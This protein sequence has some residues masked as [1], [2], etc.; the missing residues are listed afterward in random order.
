[1]DNVEHKQAVPLRHREF[2]ALLVAP[3]ATLFFY[4]LLSGTPY[5]LFGV[6]AAG[7][8]LY[9]GLIVAPGYLL[10]RRKFD[11][12]LVECMVYY[13]IAGLV[14]GLVVFYGSHRWEVVVV[15]VL[16]F[17]LPWAGLG[18]LQWLISRVQKSNGSPSQ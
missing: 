11:M 18:T 13:S 7:L 15:D 8:L 17:M 3:A 14:L 2:V 12:G 6:V 16:T 5:W 1:M 4:A 10:L 9:Y